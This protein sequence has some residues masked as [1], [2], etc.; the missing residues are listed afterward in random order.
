MDS[1]DKLIDFDELPDLERGLAKWLFELILDFAEHASVNKMTPNNLG[2]VFGP[3]VFESG[4]G[5]SKNPFAALSDSRTGTELIEKNI[6]FLLDNPDRRPLRPQKGRQVLRASNEAM[7]IGTKMAMMKPGMLIDFSADPKI[8]A[9]LAKRKKMSGDE[10]LASNQIQQIIHG[11]SK[12][13][14]LSVSSLPKGVAPRRRN[15]L[16]NSETPA[17]APAAQGEVKEARKLPPPPGMQVELKSKLAGGVNLRKIEKPQEPQGKMVIQQIPNYRHSL[18]PVSGAPMKNTPVAELKRT[19]S[20]GDGNNGTNPPARVPRP[21]SVSVGNL[22][23]GEG[24]KNQV[25]DP[26]YKQTPPPNRNSSPKPPVTSTP[27][28]PESDPVAQSKPEPPRGRPSRPLSARIPTTSKP[29]SAQ[30]PQ[31]QEP[32]KSTE[33]P[34]DIKKA[35]RRALPQRKSLVLPKSNLVHEQKE[36]PAPVKQQPTIPT[37]VVDIEPTDVPL[38]QATVTPQVRQTRGMSI[39]EIVE[40]PDWNQQAVVVTV[41]HVA[42]TLSSEIDDLDLL[43]SD[44]GSDAVK[45]LMEFIEEEEVQND[46][47][48]QKDL[49]F[50]DVPTIKNLAFH[51]GNTKPSPYHSTAPSRPSPSPPA[52]RPP[53]PRQPAVP[54]RSSLSSGMSVSPPS[55]Q[56]LQQPVAQ[57]APAP[58]PSPPASPVLPAARAESNPVEIR[59]GEDKSAKRKSNRLSGKFS[60]NMK[61]I[62]PKK[63]PATISDALAAPGVKWGRSKDAEE[64]LAKLHAEGAI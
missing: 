62:A 52:R 16:S 48:L 56:P 24:S 63:D 28:K 34:N 19:E 17:P 4:G 44:D 47:D 12:V 64:I 30:E 35:P 27:D 15:P 39:A 1:E 9:L 51:T 20:G 42:P 36:E 21:V 33:Q 54:P 13:G 14:T 11:E 59:N 38:R 55:S 10:S 8:G 22:T 61:K 60:F 25:V 6:Q 41:A 5:D 45:E 18:M 31:S 3:G 2:I 23:R 53:P 32:T 40:E 49:G 58:S 29:F 50:D 57:P 26:P 46:A 43:L 7:G 37:V